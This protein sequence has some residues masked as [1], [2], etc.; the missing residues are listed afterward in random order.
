M[1]KNKFEMFKNDRVTLQELV[2]SANQ[3]IKSFPI[4]GIKPNINSKHLEVFM[5][6]LDSDGIRF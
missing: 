5:N 2:K 6:L 1:T 3:S 4:K